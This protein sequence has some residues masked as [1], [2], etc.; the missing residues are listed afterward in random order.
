M[1]DDK[2]KYLLKSILKDP[3]S[4]PLITKLGSNRNYE[5]RPIL[6]EN[7]SRRTFEIS[8]NGSTKSNN[9][10][11]NKNDNSR[12]FELNTVNDFINA[13]FSK[14][15]KNSKISKGTNKN[16]LNYTSVNNNNLEDENYKEL[17][18]SYSRHFKHNITNIGI[19]NVDDRNENKNE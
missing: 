9:L 16:N 13:D 18:L 2:T 10:A 12:K 6:H 14:S 17:G 15:I 4:S 3:S 7:K 5:S 19:K 1:A 8:E 11:N